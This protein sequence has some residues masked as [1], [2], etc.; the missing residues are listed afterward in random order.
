[1]SKRLEIFNNYAIY[2]KKTFGIKEQKDIILSE[3][4]KQKK[5]LAE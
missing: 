4:L 2:P 5:E 3:K 1:M